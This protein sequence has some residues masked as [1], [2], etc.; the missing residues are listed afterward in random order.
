MKT[1]YL[2]LL[3]PLLLVVTATYWPIGSTIPVPTSTGTN[4]PMGFDTQLAAWWEQPDTN[5]WQAE[6]STNNIE[7]LP[8]SNEWMTMQPR[9]ARMAHAPYLGLHYTETGSRPLQWKV[10]LKRVQ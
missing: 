6:Y 8:A 7:W 1:T 3:L 9:A 10:R 5:R 4:N 2:L